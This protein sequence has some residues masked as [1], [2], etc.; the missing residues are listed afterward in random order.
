MPVFDGVMVVK[1]GLHL[2]SSPF[3]H[4]A[5]HTRR[6]IAVRV[7][8]CVEESSCGATAFVCVGFRATIQVTEKPERCDLATLACRVAENIHTY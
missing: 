5:G 8:H 2:L 6:Y 3:H 7:L 4:R 1:K